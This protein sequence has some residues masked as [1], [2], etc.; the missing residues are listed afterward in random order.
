MRQ[1]FSKQEMELINSI[2]PES[3]VK[4]IRDKLKFRKIC[5]RNFRIAQILLKAAAQGGLNLYQI[6]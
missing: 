2:D 1:P 3:D 5:L 4:L 6:A